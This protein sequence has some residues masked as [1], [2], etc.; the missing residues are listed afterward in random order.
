[1]FST[2]FVQL[3]LRLAGERTLRTWVRPLSAVIHL[4]AEFVIAIIISHL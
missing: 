3:L 1:M 2:M 4:E